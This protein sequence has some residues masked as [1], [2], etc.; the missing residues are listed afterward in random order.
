MLANFYDYSKKIGEG[1]FGKVYI[2]EHRITKKK[3]AIKQNTDMPAFLLHEG[4]ILRNLQVHKNI[5]NMV[6]YGN[7]N[8]KPTLIMELLKTSLQDIRNNT[9]VTDEV[10]LSNISNQM[11]TAIEYIHSKNIIHRDIKPENIMFK[12]N[13]QDICIIDF[14]LA[15]YYKINNN[16]VNFT[17]NMDVIGSYN[18]CSKNMNKGLRPARRDD[19]ESL[20]YVLLNLTSNFFPCNKSFAGISVSDKNEFLYN[21]K[22]SLTERECSSFIKKIVRC[23]K[24]VHALNY[25][26]EPP[27]SLLKSILK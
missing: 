4:K 26:D 12:T 22:C 19:V 3:V 10:V 20:L 25:H 11:I 7:L 24:H 6:W 13:K 1:S 27:Y 8:D 14:G 21:F 5:P 18:Y 17:K 23:I 2:G 15:K 9:I 16:H